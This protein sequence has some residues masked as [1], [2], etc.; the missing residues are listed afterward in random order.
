VKYRILDKNHVAVR[1][2]ISNMARL[3]NYA[4]IPEI[5][6]R[7]IAREM[8]EFLSREKITTTEG[9]EVTTYGMEL[10]VFSPDEFYRAVREEAQE[11]FHFFNRPVI[12]ATNGV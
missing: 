4:P 6:R 3:S 5:V 2:Q 7:D 1:H 8:A 11:M 9:P 12:G 10:Y